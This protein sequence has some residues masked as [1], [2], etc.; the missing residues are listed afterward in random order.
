MS[1]YGNLLW[2]NL[3]VAI[4][5]ATPPPR[6]SVNPYRISEYHQPESSSD[7]K[8]PNIDGGQLGT[9]VRSFAQNLKRE[10]D[11][12]LQNGQKRASGRQ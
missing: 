6:R 1:K 12:T 11:Q 4:K 7:F 3:H 2:R 10:V 8:L 9:F 5:R